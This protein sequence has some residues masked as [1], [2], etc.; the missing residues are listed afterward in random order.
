MKK[1]NKK[2]I[3]IILCLIV[4]VLYGSLFIKTFSIYVYNNIRE[5]FLTS[6]NFY[7]YSDKLTLDNA[8]YK[9]ENWSGVEDY[10]ITINM[11]SMK[12]NIKRC[13]SD[14]TYNITATSSDNIA[15]QLSK[16][17]STIPANTNEDNFKVTLTPITTLRTGDV[18]WV[19]VVAKST[20][21]Y[22]KEIKARFEVKVGNLGMSYNIEDEPNSQFLTFNVINTLNFY[23]I[24][25]AF[26]DY[27]VENKIDIDRYLSLSD[28]N[29]AKC[30]SLTVTLTFNPRDVYIDMTSETFLNAISTTTTQIDGAT[31]VNSITFKVDAITSIGVKFYK[32]NLTQNYTYPNGGNNS[33]INISYT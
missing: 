8:Q 5:F 15:C 18:V 3:L 9:A 32:K 30:H 21:P 31:Y 24:D 27:E 7:F 28:E 2:K 11:N 17:S 6:K 4:T 23:T 12:N 13:N 33:I 29:K 16:N 22:E 26:G 10:T 1:N 14:I 19:N 20:A 25:E